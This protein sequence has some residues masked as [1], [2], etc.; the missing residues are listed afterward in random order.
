MI[1]VLEAFIGRL[2]VKLRAASTESESIKI[3]LKIG[4]AQYLQPVLPGFLS[5]LELGSIQAKRESCTQCGLCV[6]GCPVR[7]IEL[8]E[9]PIVNAA[10]CQSCWKCY[11]KCPNGALYGSKFGEGFRYPKPHE[12]YRKKLEAFR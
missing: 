6:K 4:F 9:Y 5:R 8:I 2:N 10:Q 12:E 1:S 11:N 7:A 3:E